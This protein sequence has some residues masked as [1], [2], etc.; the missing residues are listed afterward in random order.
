ESPDFNGQISASEKTT[1]RFTSEFDSISRLGSGGYGHV[2]KARNKLL[3]SEM[4]VKIVLCDE[5]YQDSSLKYLYIQMELCSTENLKLWIEKM[6]HNQNQERKKKSLSIFRQ[7]VSGVEYIHS[8]NLIHRDLKPENI[9]F[10][11]KEKE[12]VKIGDFGLVTVGAFEAKNLEERT[13]YK[14]TPWYMPPE[15]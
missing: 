4:A 13:V 14:G 5:P 8:R 2:F 1:P 9:M 10:S 12:K 7:I 15:Q 6:N 11:K 3:G